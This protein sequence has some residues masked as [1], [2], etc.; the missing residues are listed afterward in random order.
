MLA[1]KLQISQDRHEQIVEIVSHAAGKLADHLDL[2]HL[3][4]LLFGALPLLDL[5]ENGG[6]GA[7]QVRGALRDTLLEGFVQMPQIGFGVSAVRH[8]GGN[9]DEA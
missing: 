5:R 4:Q 3:P 8:I 1:Q 6:I 2:L 7:L 9:A